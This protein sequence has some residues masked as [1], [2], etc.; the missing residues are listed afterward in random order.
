RTAYPRFKRLLSAREL[1]VF[2]TP[3]QD[4]VAWARGVAGSD[5]HAL[6]LVVWLKC[7]GRLGYFPALDSVPTAVVGHVRRDLGLTEEI[8]AVHASARTAERH[9]DL[10]RRRF[11]V[12]LDQGGARKVAADAIREAARARN[13]PPDLINIAL[14][15]LVEGCFELPAFSTLDKMA[16]RIRGE[17]NAEI[18]AGI[19][20]R[21]GRA[22]VARLEALPDPAGP[23][24]KTDFD[25]LKRS[26]P[27]PSWTN[28]R[29]QLDHLRWVDGLG[30]AAGWVEGVAASKLADFAGEAGAAVMRDYGDAKRIALLAALVA[31]AQGKAR[32]DVA[33]MFCRRVATLTKRARDELE[34]LR[35]AHRAVTERL[36]A[37]YRAVLERIDPDGPAGAQQQAALEAARKAVLDAGGLAGQ[38]ADIGRVSAHHGDNHAPLVARHFRNDRAAMLSMA[39]ALDL[40]ATSADRSVLAALEFV[41]EHA[42]LTRDHVSDR[43][44]A[45]GGAG[46]PGAQVLD[47]SF[48]SED[49]RRAIRDRKHPGM[50]VRRHLEACV[51]TYLAEELRTGDIAVAGAQAYANWADQLLSPEECAQ[52]LPAFCAETGLPGDGPGFRADLQ[53]K[54]SA[55]C[56][57]CDGGYPDNADLVIDDQ[58]VPSLKRYRAAPPTATALALETAIAER[59]PER[60]L[61][62]ILARTG[63]WL[64]WWR[65]FGPASGSEPKL[66]DAFFRYTLTTFTYGS[67]LG[68]AQ[69]A[70]HMAGISAHELGATARRHATIGKLNLAIA[71]VV[72]AFS[73]LDL[74]R[75]WGDGAT[76]AADGTQVETFIDN[77]LAETSIR[78][79]GTGGIAYHYISDTYIALFSR[80][81]PVGV[82]EAVYLIE[83]LLQQESKVRPG[84]VHADT[85]GQSFPVF[86]LAHLFGFDLM[87]RIR[88]WKDLNF[89]R[90]SA[91]ARYRHIDALFGEPGRNVIDWDLIEN[92]YSDLMR[93]VLSIQAG[94][95]SSVTL[96]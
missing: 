86:A 8:A 50:F 6:A 22:V 64:E 4:E 45:D 34:A 16:S 3:Q 89:Y 9:R 74:A 44:C 92:H 39:G 59:M 75:A 79:G 18:F 15:R 42:A 19:A 37:N 63:H 23:G 58:G 83:G 56:A 67:N 73:E 72:D 14:E 84:T 82:W 85:Q 35:E 61:L 96:L 7:F 30:D 36:I 55:R 80:F 51:L 66:A 81:I 29:K 60:T 26:A 43:V 11:G 70:R 49:W 91:G 33:E 24:G 40:Q 32:D 25:R 31:A 12:V 68:P 38:Y 71:D 41:R 76:V 78:Y 90:P 65:R 88:N 1:H 87:P 5:E 48:A 62:G 13:H 17:V 54:L 77:L 2:F 93:V 57:D 95:I 10:I 94:K 53:G 69:A 52:L 20:G 46:R 28:F 27:R 21:A 47:T